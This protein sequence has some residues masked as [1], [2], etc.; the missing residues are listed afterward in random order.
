MRVIWT[1]AIIL[2]LSVNLG[3]APSSQANSVQTSD[4]VQ[5][6]DPSTPILTTLAIDR[7]P[8]LDQPATLTCNISTVIDAPGSQVQFEL[9]EDV[10]LVSGSLTWQGD[11]L[12]GH[13]VQLVAIITFTTPGEK[14]IFCRALRPIDANN[15]WG[16][17]SQLYLTVGQSN[18]QAG[19]PPIPLSQ[20]AHLAVQVKAGAGVV[21]QNSSQA[22]YHPSYGQ[23]VVP[24]GLD[25]RLEGAQPLALS[26]APSGSLTVTGQW[27]YYDRSGDLASAEMLVEAV[28]GNDGSHLAWCYTG[29]SGSY[30]CGPFANPAEAGVRILW[31]SYMRYD[32][33]GDILATINPNWG[34]TNDISHTYSISTNPVIFA[35]GTHDIGNWI[36]PNGD[37]YERAFWV[38]TDLVNAW[39]YIWFGAGSLQTP[40]ETAGSGTV[41][42]KIDSNDGAY[43]SWGG[44][45]HLAGTDP[46][47]NTTVDHE[48]GHQI[49]YTVYH[50]SLPD[51][52][53]P[54][55]HYIQWASGP[56]C[57]WVEGWADFLPLAINNDPVYRWWYGASLD[58]ETPTWGTVPY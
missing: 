3:A 9:P 35:D 5:K 46:L 16:D 29:T 42:W 41:Q 12:V 43:Y 4:G 51:N 58:L 8:A 53:C 18:G 34:L 22:S 55:P 54:T 19:F 10:H 38:T 37:P 36:V 26:D 15:T 24:P 56:H 13:P 30:S 6:D 50:N 48:Y 32:P 21:V 45:I 57:G 11:L 52:D 27:H 17:L 39:R 28:K 20:H 25:V 14:S 33:S 23:G 2:V 40:P 7:F 31:Y 47:S 44:N 49:M 1:M